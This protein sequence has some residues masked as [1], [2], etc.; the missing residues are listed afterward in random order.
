MTIVEAKKYPSIARV[1]DM[2]GNRTFTYQAFLENAP[3]GE[4]IVAV[5]KIHGINCRVNI[6]HNGMFDV[7]GRDGKIIKFA[8]E[9]IYKGMEYVGLVEDLVKRLYAFT[10]G[11]EVTVYFE[12]AGGQG[13]HQIQP[14][15]DYC[16]NQFIYIFDVSIDGKLLSYLDM[17]KLL[18]SALMSNGR[19][20]NP[21]IVY[22]S[23]PYIIND[24]QELE[25]YA[26]PAISKINN[27]NIPGAGYSF[28]PFRE[29]T[30]F[31]GYV[32]DI[33]L[34]LGD[35][36]D[37]PEYRLILKR[38]NPEF[39]EVKIVIKP[40]EEITDNAKEIFEKIKGYCTKIRLSKV[41]GN[42]DKMREKVIEM[43]TLPLFIEAFTQDVLTDYQAD[44]NGSLDR[45]NNKEKDEVR[46][47]VKLQL[48]VLTKNY[49]I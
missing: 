26:T 47:I 21:H 4:P 24:L 25:K 18:N 7:A 38:I 13:N 36:L 30:I 17:L 49:H 9:S 45:L 44:T 3:L 33:K 27:E 12:L 29:G 28:R 2:A 43:K 1:F 39:E 6:H 40:A 10:A 22:D 42:L 48:V 5:E 37:T 34:V 19:F 16:W 11:H 15:I 31:R 8:Q 41:V 20:I 14:E 23:T 35:T 46:K 32:K